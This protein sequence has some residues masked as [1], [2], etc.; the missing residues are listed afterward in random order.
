MKCT[1]KEGSGLALSNLGH[2]ICT[3]TSTRGQNAYSASTALSAVPLQCTFCLHQK[4]G[5]YRQL[6]LII[7][8]VHFKKIQNVM[9]TNLFSTTGPSG[10]CCGEIVH[11]IRHCTALSRAWTSTM[12][13]TKQ[14]YTVRIFH[15]IIT[16]C[17]ELTC[18]VRILLLQQEPKVRIVPGSE[19]K[20]NSLSGVLRRGWRKTSK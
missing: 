17:S 11:Y 4:N 1:C 15:T 3:L 19:K 12:T 13:S 7:F 9:A 6:L 5:Q 16:L 2:W 10:R 20:K 8:D 18:E 14:A